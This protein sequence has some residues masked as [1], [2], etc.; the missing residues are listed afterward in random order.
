MP[1]TCPVAVTPSRQNTFTKYPDARS[2]VPLNT[3]IARG[4]CAPSQASNI[5]AF[6]KSQFLLRA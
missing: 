6:T 1:W 2:M 5:S 4:R 3:G